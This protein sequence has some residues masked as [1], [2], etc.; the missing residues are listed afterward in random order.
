MPGAESRGDGAAVS[1]GIVQAFLWRAG[2]LLQRETVGSAAINCNIA[3]TPSIRLLYHDKGIWGG[4][5]D[6]SR[7]HPIGNLI[8]HHALLP[9]HDDLRGSGTVC[10]DSDSCG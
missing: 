1:E 9:R 7:L 6:R 10:N 2:D 3:G 8:P 5:R 4:N